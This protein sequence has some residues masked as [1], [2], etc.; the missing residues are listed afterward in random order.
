MFFFLLALVFSLV[1][2]T[3]LPHLFY[4]FLLIA[5]FLL[6]ISFS[7]EGNTLNPM[8]ETVCSTPPVTITQESQSFCINKS[9]YFHT[10]K[11]HRR[12]R[13]YASL[14]WASKTG[15]SSSSSGRWQTAAAKPFRRHSVH[16]DSWAVRSEPGCRNW[17]SSPKVPSCRNRS[18]D[19][20]RPDRRPCRCSVLPWCRSYC[21]RCCSVR[22]PGFGWTPANCKSDFSPAKCFPPYPWE[23][24]GL[25]MV[26]VL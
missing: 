9:Y 15:D 4:Y 18:S 11:F 24:N 25:M 2:L 23:G 17:Y 7:L 14:T 1:S 5:T 21:S 20:L 13:M 19:N 12:I 22:V 6:R 8:N 16:S 26:A 3:Y 10:T